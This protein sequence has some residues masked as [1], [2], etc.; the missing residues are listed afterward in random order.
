MFAEESVLVAQNWE[1]VEDI[2]QATEKLQQ[3]LTSMLYSIEDDLAQQSWW[4]GGWNFEQHG[5]SQIYISNKRWLIEEHDNYALW[6]GVENVT[7]KHIFGLEPPPNLYVWVWDRQ[8]W[9]DLVSRLINELSQ[10][11]Y[12]IIG[13]PETRT[14]SYVIRGPLKKYRPGVDVETYGQEVQQEI[15][16]FFSCYASILLELDSTIQNHIK[17]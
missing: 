3:D 5:D 7:P 11:K 16:E 1:I 15:I 13:E 10:A 6:V 2:M 14:N 9:P 4:A 8:R 17:K 12:E